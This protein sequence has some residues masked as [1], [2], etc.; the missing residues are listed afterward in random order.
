M[1]NATRYVEQL[2]AVYYQRARSLSNALV[3]PGRIETYR[4]ANGP[5]EPTNFPFAVGG[6]NRNAS[7]RKPERC[8]V[9]DDVAGRGSGEVGADDKDILVGPFGEQSSAGL[10]GGL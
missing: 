6:V 10:S 8:A 3:S 2:R 4:N 7:H 5:V 1:G 9:A